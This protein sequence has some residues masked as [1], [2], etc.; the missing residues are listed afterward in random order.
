MEW[1][2]VVAG[3]LL[4]L[5]GLLD[6]FFSVLYYD[7]FGFLSSRLYTRLFDVVRFVTRGLPRPYRAL[8][9]S[10]AAPLMVPVTITVWIFLLEAREPCQLYP[11]WGGANMSIQCG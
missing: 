8:G 6:V 9:L 1:L 5:V 10:M 3:V 11:R 4:I 2:S 7:G